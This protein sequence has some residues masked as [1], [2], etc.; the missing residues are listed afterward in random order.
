MVAGLID[1][2]LRC[3]GINKD[4]PESSS[5]FILAKDDDQQDVD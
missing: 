2:D 5:D 1:P 4:E 3:N